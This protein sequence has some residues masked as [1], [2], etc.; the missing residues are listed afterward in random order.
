MPL[1]AQEPQQVVVSMISLRQSSEPPQIL[2]EA[3]GSV[4]GAE[5][6][7][8]L[9][10]LRDFLKTLEPGFT[11][12]AVYPDLVML[13]NDA[14][15]SLFYFIARIFDAEPGRFLMVDGGRSPYPGL[16]AFIEQLGTDGQ[17]IFTETVEEARAIMREDT[18][19]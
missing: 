9:A 4:S 18:S 10:P 7:R 14:V 1:Y 8:E 2:V 16:R 17:V 11:V 13:K 6:R 3:A 15:E 5:V 19:S 12:M